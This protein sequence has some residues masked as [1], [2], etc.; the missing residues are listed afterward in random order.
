MR[1]VGSAVKQR[2]KLASVSIVAY[3]TL[4]QWGYIIH[5]YPGQRTGKM[6]VHVCLRTYSHHGLA[7]P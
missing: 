3:L 2:N 1:I 5:K 4:L 6:V 7:Y